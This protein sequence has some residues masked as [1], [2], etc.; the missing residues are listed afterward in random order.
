MAQDQTLFVGYTEPRN[1]S[2]APK[3]CGYRSRE[4]G[5]FVLG[6]VR[7]IVTRWRTALYELHK[8]SAPPPTHHPVSSLNTAEV[9]GMSGQMQDFYAIKLAA[10]ARR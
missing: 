7:S 4:S 2:N 10:S 8:M 9:K 3:S 6:T 5:H 1:E